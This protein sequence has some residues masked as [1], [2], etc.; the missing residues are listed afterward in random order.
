MY[1]TITIAVLFF[2][3]ATI[4]SSGGILLALALLMAFSMSLFKY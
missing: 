3:L 1:I 2:V 4:R